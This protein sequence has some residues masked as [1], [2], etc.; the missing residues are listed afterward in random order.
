MLS[1]SPIAD[2]YH[3]YINFKNIATKNI[4]GLQASKGDSFEQL[5]TSVFEVLLP[6]NASV[7]WSEFIAKDSRPPTLK[8]FLNFI[9]KRIVNTET[10]SNTTQRSTPTVVTSNHSS[11]KPTPKENMCPKTFH[12][13]ENLRTEVC[14]ACNGAHSIYQCAVFEAWNVSRGHEFVRH[15]HLCSTVL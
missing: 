14:P 7:I 2:N 15:K 8:T 4:N 3:S 6:H 10:L 13:K 1:L 5:L 12:M 11:S 9:D